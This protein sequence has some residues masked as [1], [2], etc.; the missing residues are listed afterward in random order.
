[1]RT[2]VSQN[3]PEPDL[4]PPTAP[5]MPSCGTDPHRVRGTMPGMKPG[6][7]LGHEGVGHG[8]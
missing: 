8:A 1:L 2:T 5:A 6:T 4:R 7:I 3:L